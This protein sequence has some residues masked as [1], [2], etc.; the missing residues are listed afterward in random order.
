MTKSKTEGGIVMPKQYYFWGSTPVAAS[1]AYAG[2]QNMMYSDYLRD[3]VARNR[4]LENSMGRPR[5]RGFSPR[6][7]ML[8]I[9]DAI[10]AGNYEKFYK[11]AC[12]YE[13]D[14]GTLLSIDSMISFRRTNGRIGKTSIMNILGWYCNSSAH[15]Q[16]LEFII[17]DAIN[18]TRTEI[19][20]LSK[21]GLNSDK[22]INSAEPNKYH[23]VCY[24]SILR[25]CEKGTKFLHF[26]HAIDGCTSPTFDFELIVTGAFQIGLKAKQTESLKHLIDLYTKC[27]LRYV[28][29]WKKWAIDT[30]QPEIQDYLTNKVT[31][32]MEVVGRVLRERGI[33]RF[34]DIG[35]LAYGENPYYRGNI[36]ANQIARD[37]QLFVNY[38]DAIKSFFSVRKARELVKDNHAD[39]DP[40]RN[41]LRSEGWTVLHIVSRNE[42]NIMDTL[43]IQVILDCLGEEAKEVIAQP[44]SN[45][46]TPLHLL[47][48]DYADG[49][50]DLNA[51]KAMF[52]AAKEK[53]SEIMKM[54]T[55][56]GETPLDIAVKHNPNN[57][58]LISLLKTYQSAK[59]TKAMPLPL[60]P[61][62]K[63]VVLYDFEATI[64]EQL[65]IKEGE[66]LAI[67]KKDDSGWWTCRQGS[68][69]GI[70]PSN[71]LKELRTQARENPS[72]VSTATRFF[73][74][75]GM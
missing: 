59:D 72:Q 11:F 39:S 57:N 54:T 8:N 26:P 40:K 33:E 60:K 23:M 13:D 63:A 9:S 62:G 38:L 14:S 16:M 24:F 71:F 29:D 22:T 2:M 32:A 1:A 25:K 75:L 51:V 6:D 12:I 73:R 52:S 27:F 34:S 31:P 30:N 42:Q 65:S 21:F 53:A 4:A 55:K 15:V 18:L 45:G 43:A 35:A 68:K 7:T 20:F 19:R 50:M 58:E 66:T 41:S 48:R 17:P 74:E 5:N 10:K 47:L 70:A 67:L 46:F 3:C 49:K 44:D 61:V 69:E 36:Q 64:P 56:N 28:G 37:S